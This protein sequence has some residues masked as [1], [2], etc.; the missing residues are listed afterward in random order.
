MLFIF[1]N[2]SFSISLNIQYNKICKL[3]ILV[4][5]FYAGDY[6]ID[7]NI[8]NIK[9]RHYSISKGSLT[10]FECLK[11]LYIYIYIYIYTHIYIYIDISKK[12]K[13]RYILEE[14]YNRKKIYIRFLW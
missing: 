14:I 10:L 12:I 9:V 5:S 1:S 2:S 4:H 6:S 8:P 11:I 7:C 3:L 13:T